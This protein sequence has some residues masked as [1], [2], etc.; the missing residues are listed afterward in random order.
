MTDGAAG[1]GGGGSAR[2]TG[3]VRSGR[4]RL[5]GTGGFSRVA[6]ASGALGFWSAATRQH[7]RQ[8]CLHRAQ[9]RGARA[10]RQQGN[11]ATGQ[12]GKKRRAPP[13]CSGEGGV[14]TGAAA[15]GEELDEAPPP[16]AGGDGGCCP[17]SPASAGASAA[18]A[19]VAFGRS[20]LASPSVRR[21]M[22]ARRSS[23]ESCF[24]FWRRRCRLFACFFKSLRTR[25]R[26]FFNFCCSSWSWS[27]VSEQSKA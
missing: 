14:G 20:L 1:A 21:S 4:N 3:A 24:A 8:P 12:Q 17:A 9:A 2:G 18:A 22:T 6:L 11:K 26:S 13:S 27:I 23:L 19:G 5:Q 25:S 7:V 10:T 16:G 15:E